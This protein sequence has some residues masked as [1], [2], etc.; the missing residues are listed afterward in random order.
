MHSSG[1]TDTDFSHVPAWE[2]RSY[3]SQWIFYMRLSVKGEAASTIPDGQHLHPCTN[4]SLVAVSTMNTVR[5]Q[6]SAEE[7]YKSRGY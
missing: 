5:A 7:S 6:P 2:T 3:E 1:V 4:V